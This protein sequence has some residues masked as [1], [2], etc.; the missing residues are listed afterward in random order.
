MHLAVIE[1]A[2]ATQSQIAIA[3]LDRIVAID[4]RRGIQQPDLFPIL[5]VIGCG[6][7]ATWSFIVTIVLV[8]SFDDCGPEGRLFPTS[9]L[10]ITVDVGLGFLSG[11]YFFATG[12]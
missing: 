4:V 2:T 7:A 8:G 1:H 5:A 3:R 10:S 12:V 11:F 6:G 9:A